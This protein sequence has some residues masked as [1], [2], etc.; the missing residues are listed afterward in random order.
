MSHVDVRH[1]ARVTTRS[2]H[3]SAFL[4]RSALGALLGSRA[5]PPGVTRPRTAMAAVLTATVAALTIS[6]CTHRASVS[7]PPA[8]AHLTSLNAARPAQNTVTG[9]VLR[10][11]VGI[12]GLA[13]E[14]NAQQNSTV[15]S[16]EPVG[17][18]VPVMTL[19][20]SMTDA[21]GKYVITLNKDAF[22]SDYIE[23]DSIINVEIDIFSRQD[24]LTA[25][26]L[27]LDYS[28]AN[29]TRPVDAAFDL[30]RHTV[31]VDGEVSTLPD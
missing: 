15:V 10:S 12:G 4:T 7:T 11:G 21:D 25:W 2:V 1:E 26:F 22:T 20:R 13:V 18:Q 5:A 29:G 24:Q 14:V 23:G 30:G 31:T 17:A 28:A 19:G 8:P 9:H 27:P 6:G 3:E 16:T